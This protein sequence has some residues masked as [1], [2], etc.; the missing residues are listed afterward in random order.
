MV[1]LY[2]AAIHGMS[3]GA[4]SRPFAYLQKHDQYIGY[5]H[6]VQLP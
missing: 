2:M 4:T 1:A 5:S 6:A 3:S